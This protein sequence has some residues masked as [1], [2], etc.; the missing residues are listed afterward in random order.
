MNN[1]FINLKKQMF[2]SKRLQ[3]SLFI[4]FLFIIMAL[5]APLSPYDPNKIDI[6]N[7]LQSPSSKNI[8]GT[9]LMGRDYFTRILYGGRISISI[10]VLSMII[11]TILG[12]IIGTISGYLEGKID[13]FIMR[14][15]DIL[16]SI[17][18]FFIILVL[19]AYFKP[20][21]KTIVFIIGFLGWMDVARLVR[22]ETLKSKNNEYV[23]YAKSIGVSKYKII[24]KHIIPNALPTIIV[25]S[26]IIIAN[27][28]LTESTLSFLGMGV[29]APDA[30]WGSM[31]NNAQGFIQTAPYLGIFPGLCI[32]MV[33][34][35]FNIL[36]DSIREALE[37]RGDNK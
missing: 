15:V 28:I 12:T 29:Q 11:S 21:I 32:F 10:G 3:I 17:P 31:L 26:T 4:I 30:S 20:G 25:A 35:S 33:V 7:R 36:G 8:F 5:L 13:I 34:L 14:I 18:S 9:D 24:L 22:G 16:M 6:T 23:L 27:S 1:I 2:K 37:V 19:N